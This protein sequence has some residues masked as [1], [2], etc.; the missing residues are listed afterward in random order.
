M[1]ANEWKRRSTERILKRAESAGLHGIR[2]RSLK[3]ATN[4]SRGIKDD[5]ELSAD[6]WWLAIE[7][8]Q[9]RKKIVIHW[10]ASEEYSNR[11]TSAMVFIAWAVQAR[12]VIGLSSPMKTPTKASSVT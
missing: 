6:Q 4:Y 11:N 5:P 9:N 3:R 2:L 7:D 12:S 8:L 1:T 10:D